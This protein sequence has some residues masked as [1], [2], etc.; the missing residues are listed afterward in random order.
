MRDSILPIIDKVLL[1]ISGENNFV[2]AI[3]DQL[4]SVLWHAA[5]T[6]VHW[7]LLVA[8]KNK[9]RNLSSHEA[10]SRCSLHI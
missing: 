2:R 1:G 8:Q 3:L 9:R 6:V 10:T 4:E 5:S 7:Y